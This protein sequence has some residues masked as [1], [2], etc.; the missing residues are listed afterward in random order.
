M[1]EMIELGDANPTAS[2]AI[3]PLESANPQMEEQSVAGSEK[4]NVKK[5]KFFPRLLRYMTTPISVK[6]EDLD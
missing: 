3:P 5:R 4:M 2:Q 6:W 1:I